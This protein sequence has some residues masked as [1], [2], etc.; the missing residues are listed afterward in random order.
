MKRGFRMV[1]HW[2]RR[3]AFAALA[4]IAGLAPAAAP[5]AATVVGTPR[6]ERLVGTAG[7]DTMV[8]RGGH[9]LLLGLGGNDT[10]FAGRGSDRVVGGEGNDRVRGGP[11][12]DRLRGGNGSDQILGGAGSDLAIGGSADDRLL[13]GPGN[14][15]LFG[16]PGNDVVYAG[17][18]HDLMVGNAG[19]DDLWSLAAADVAVPGVDTLHGQDGNH[20]FRTRDGEA[21]SIDCGTGRDTALLDNVDV[22]VDA[23]A[24]NPNGSCEKVKRKT[25]SPRDQQKENGTE[26][27]REPS[28]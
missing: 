16:G 15:R 26:S 11:G 23:T 12:H 14:D 8:G 17:F 25:P 7:P 3:T 27:P 24:A 28:S 5:T 6:G 4:I 9:D 10:A 1:R 21:D 2:T 18:G 13:G 20:R 19:N 22:I